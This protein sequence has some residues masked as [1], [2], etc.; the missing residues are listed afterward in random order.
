MNIRRT[1]GSS[2]PVTGVTTVTR[3]PFGDGNAASQWHPAMREINAYAQ[4]LGIGTIS[5]R[6]SGVFAKSMNPPVNATELQT[7]TLTWKQ[8]GKKYDLGEILP[9][10][11]HLREIKSTS[12]LVAEMKQLITKFG[13]R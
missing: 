7:I 8:D 11:A 13:Q 3:L 2:A 6:G 9:E 12:E 1:S 5:Y 10:G 4:Q